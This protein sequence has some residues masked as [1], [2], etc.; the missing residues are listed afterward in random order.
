MDNL[1][2]NEQMSIIREKQQCKYEA[3]IMNEED[4]Y[5]KKYQ[6]QQQEQQE[7]ERHRIEQ[8]Q[9]QLLQHEMQQE[10]FR[11]EQRIEHL[12]MESF[13][14]DYIVKELNRHKHTY[15]NVDKI[16]NYAINLYYDRKIIEE[17]DREFEQLTNLQGV[18]Y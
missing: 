15:V 16:R 4:L 12:K 14:N 6:N 2:F 10:I 1:S 18:K 13:V 9:L 8:E 11:E 3:K 5:S 7:L 17:Q